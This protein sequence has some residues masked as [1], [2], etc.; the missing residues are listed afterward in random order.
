VSSAGYRKLALALPGAEE[1]SHF[2]NPDFRVRG[3]I[4]AGFNDKGMA[5]LKLLP[6]QQ[7]ML[8][9]A[10][11]AVIAPIPG[12]WGKKGWTLVNQD[13]AD[14]DLLKSVLLMA[15]KN[16]APKSLQK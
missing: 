10:A 2:G 3:K 16:V 1:D 12:A 5:Y 8:V 13:L 14:I 4:F 9:A 6:E 7:H 15:W 11:P